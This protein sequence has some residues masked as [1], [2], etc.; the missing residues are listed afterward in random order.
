MFKLKNIQR[1]IEKNI[2]KNINIINRVKYWFILAKVNSERKKKLYA[3]N[4]F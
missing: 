1:L 4:I 3:L 2:K